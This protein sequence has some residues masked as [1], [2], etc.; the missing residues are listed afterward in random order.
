MPGNKEKKLFPDEYCERTR[1]FIGVGEKNSPSRDSSKS[2]SPWGRCPQASSLGTIEDMHSC[3]LPRFKTRP[4]H[5]SA[6]V[7]IA[8]YTATGSIR[9]RLARNRQGVKKCSLEA[10]APLYIFV[11]KD[12]SLFGAQIAS[13]LSCRVG[14]KLP[15]GPRVEGESPI[16]AHRLDK[17]LWR[18]TGT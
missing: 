11:S 1:H 18:R 15:K 12:R 10:P 17:T 3:A 8:S 14:R 7:L 5:R 4:P 2:G 9:W 13:T 16:G 6:G